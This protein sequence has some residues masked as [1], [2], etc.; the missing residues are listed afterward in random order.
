M[1]FDVRVRQ[2]S[3]GKVTELVGQNSLGCILAPLPKAI[4]HVTISYVAH[5]SKLQI[6]TNPNE[7]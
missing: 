3:L 1:N 6:E 2:K 7:F 5:R 4:Y